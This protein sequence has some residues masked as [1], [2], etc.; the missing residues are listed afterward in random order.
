MVAQTGRG[1]GQDGRR[2]PVRA[3]TRWPSSGPP[4][5]RGSRPRGGRGAS[6][7][8]DGIP[9][10]SYPSAD[11]P[12]GGGGGLP[13]E[14]VRLQK[15]LAQ[16]GVGS[17]RVCEDLIDA[18]RVEVD[19]QRVRT[20]GMRVDPATAVIRVDGLRIPSLP[21]TVY[22]ALNKPNGVVSTM[23][24]PEGRPNLGDYVADRELRLFHVGRLDVDTEGLILLTNDGELAQ[25]L[26]H[27]SYGV[28]KTYLAQIEGPVP[29]DLGRRLRAGIDLDDGLAR[30]DGFRLVDSLG[31]EALVEVVLH[32]G[33][34]RVV[35]RMLEAA[36]HPVGRLVRT[37]FGPVVL[38]DQRSGRLRPLSNVEVGQLYAAC[39]L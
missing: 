38:G 19:G 28:K 3:H 37:R 11:G 25:R 32:E 2:Q 12:G 35:R 30:A 18:G 7:G 31:R 29:R 17:R 24:D 20:Q 36:G 9:P 5:G 15:V 6:G 10:E 27:P 26:T 14:G 39:G 33:R 23:S 16:A 21:Q 13:T 22:L 34:Y 1:D 4:P 8:G